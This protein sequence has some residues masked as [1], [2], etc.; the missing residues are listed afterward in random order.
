MVSDGRISGTEVLQ[1]LCMPM[2][3]DV[4][5]I[6]IRYKKF[7]RSFMFVCFF[8]NWKKIIGCISRYFIALIFSLVATLRLYLCLIQCGATR[9]KT[10]R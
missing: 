4:N 2:R 6:F 5:N 3:F 1:I 10:V 9:I 8:Y 7:K